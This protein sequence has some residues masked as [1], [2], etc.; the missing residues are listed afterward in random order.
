MF[1]PFN[2]ALDHLDAA[3]GELEQIRDNK[4]PAD[5]PEFAVRALLARVD[6]AGDEVER[7]F[8]EIQSPA[9]LQRL[10]DA[11]E[12]ISQPGDAY[13]PADTSFA[14]RMWGRPRRQGLF[15]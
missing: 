9:F 8:E 4:N 15:R 11:F 6:R 14:D 1:G 13:A 3:V 7:R 5:V 2:D 10:R 12:P